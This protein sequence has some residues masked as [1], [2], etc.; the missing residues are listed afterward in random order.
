METLPQTWPLTL[1]PNKVSY[2]DLNIFAHVALTAYNNHHIFS[3]PL[4]TIFILLNFRPQSLFCHCM[5]SRTC[6]HKCS[7]YLL[8]CSFN[9]NSSYHF[10]CINHVPSTVLGALLAFALFSQQPHTFIFPLLM[11]KMRCREIK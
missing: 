8:R 11:N 5:T 7:M 6:Q 2:S 10:F 9:K 4:M 1:S 3:V